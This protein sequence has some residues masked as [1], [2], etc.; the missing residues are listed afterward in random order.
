MPGIELKDTSIVRLR[1]CRFVRESGDRYAVVRRAGT[2]RVVVRAAGLAASELFRVGCTIE[3][4][5][6][7]LAKRFQ[8]ARHTIDLTPLLRSLTNADLIA[9]VDGKPL[10][11]VCK[12]SL[13]SAYR[14]YLRY[15]LSPRLLRVA[16]DQLPL[17]LGRKLAY[18]VWWAD[19]R[20]ALW[21]R[22]LHAA[23]RFASC[24]AGARPAS[25][26]RRFASRYFSHLVQ[27]FVDFES[28]AAMTPAQA[29]AWFQKHVEYEGLE[30]LARLKNDRVP[31]IVGGFHFSTI[32]LVALLLTRRG[33]DTTQVWVPD[34]SLSGEAGKWLLEFGKLNSGFGRLGHVPG[35]TLPHYRQ[36]IQSVRKGE[37]L[38]WFSDSPSGREGLDPERLERRDE[39]TKVF[40]IPEFR[41][42]LPQSKMEVELCGQRVYLSG[43]VGAFARLTGAAV[44]PAALVR[45]GGRLRMI[46]KPPLRLPQPC[47]AKHVEALNRALFGELDALLHQYP[48]QWFLW[49]SMAQPS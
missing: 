27:N 39:L 31:I 20:A 21:P 38:V 35:F 14:Y 11:E 34:R 24:P 45:A 1:P 22:A 9:S 41:T 8:V 37:V 12:P 46:L 10:P 48:D 13:V 3:S 18:W 6:L 16:Y 2:S 5:K 29:E 26:S 4:A 17:T 19:A 43:R 42:G 30:H 33:H 28:I 36:L 47:D 40:Q 44:V 7:H 23:E 25:G 49:H 32:K 15:H